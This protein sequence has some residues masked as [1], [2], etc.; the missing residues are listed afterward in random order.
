ML[1]SI[2]LVLLPKFRYFMKCRTIKE[3]LH[4]MYFKRLS[5]EN[6]FKKKFYKFNVSTYYIYL[7]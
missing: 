2:R 5:V 4:K 1:H 7:H 6:T 3:R